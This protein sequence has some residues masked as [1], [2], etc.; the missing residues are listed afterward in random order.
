MRHLALA[1]ILMTSPCFAQSAPEAPQPREPAQTD[2][3]VKTSDECGASRYAHLVGQSY[4]VHAASLP[5]GSVI[6]GGA[7]AGVVPVD[8]RVQAAT[9]PLTLEYRE[10]RLNIVL[11]GAARIV[12]IACH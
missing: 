7:P 1:L 5:P 3:F 9:S 8:Q 10:Q 6:H 11:D 12:S 2:A 4:A